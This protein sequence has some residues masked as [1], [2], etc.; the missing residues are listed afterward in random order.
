MMAPPKVLDASNARCTVF[1]FKEGLLSTVAHDLRIRVL[2]FSI[3]A[4]LE[5]GSVT[6]RFDP[7]TL[8]VDCA[9]RDGVENPRALSSRDSAEIDRIIQDQV[10][11]TSRFPEITLT[12]G[13]I[14]DAFDGWNVS[15]KLSLH[16][17]L[18][19]ISARVLR[20]GEV[21]STEVRLYQPDFG[22]PPFTALLGTL[23]IKPDII[24][25]IETA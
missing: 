14:S 5:R 6:A 25:R 17:T 18:R 15:G 10:L 16:G 1:T 20:K 12:S 7:R 13:S 2:R 21:L 9:M 22:I 19:S 11:H 4:D 8:R 23:K 3:E 24:V